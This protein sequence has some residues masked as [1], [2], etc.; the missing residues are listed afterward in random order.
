MVIWIIKM[1]LIRENIVISFFDSL[2]NWS[3]RLSIFHGVEER[4]D[5]GGKQR[6]F[7]FESTFRGA[8]GRL[9]QQRRV[10]V[11]G[12]RGQKVVRGVGGVGG[13]RGT[14]MFLPRS[15]SMLEIARAAGERAS[16]RWV[17]FAFSQGLRGSPRPLLL[18]LFSSSLFQTKGKRTPSTDSDSLKFIIRLVLLFTAFHRVRPRASS[19]DLVLPLHETRLFFSILV[20]SDGGSISW[21]KEQ[22][23]SVCILLWTIDRRNRRRDKKRVVCCSRDESGKMCVVPM[24]LTRL[25]S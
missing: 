10:V 2:V 5:R 13:R 12:R 25:E 6:A 1:T 23:K 16:T 18:L 20:T 9:S 3:K 4:I 7:R 17:G 19:I 15:G 11:F 8:R 21:L 24:W 14:R 22:N